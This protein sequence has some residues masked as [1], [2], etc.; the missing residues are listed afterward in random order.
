MKGALSWQPQ[1][2]HLFVAFNTHLL[3]G[4]PLS[5]PGK[6]INDT[7]VATLMHQRAVAGYQMNCKDNTKIV[8]KDT[9]LLSLWT[10]LERIHDSPLKD[11]YFRGV[12]N[13]WTGTDKGRRASPGS[14]PRMADNKADQ[15]YINTNTKNIDQRRSALSACGF[16][17]TI[18]GLD[19]VLLDLQEQEE[20]DKA[21]AWA[22]FNGLPDRA[23]DILSDAKDP[24]QGFQRKLISMVLEGCR[25]NSTRNPTWQHLCDLLIK[26][27]DA[28]PYL[29][30]IFKYIASNDWTDVLDDPLIPLQERLVIALRF[31]E[32]NQLSGW[33]ARVL[34]T[35]TS[36]GDVQGL[37]VTGLYTHG[38]NLL[39]NY[40]D[41]TGDVQSAAFI[42][43]FVMPR[44]IQDARCEE[45]VECYRTLLDRWQLWRQRAKFDIERGKLMH[46]TED[47]AP[48][49][50]YV[51][52]SYCAQTL[53][54]RIVAPNVKSRDG[55]RVNVQASVSPS[56][57]NRMAGKQKINICSSC[58]KALPRCA[59]CL[60]NLGTPNDAMRQA[61][62]TN[63]A[64][65]EDPS[66]LNMWF[67][68]CQTCR[69]GGHAIHMSEWFKKHS[70]CPVSN[71]ACQCQP[72]S[73]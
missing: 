45:W 54:H 13:I 57:N 24:S 4:D 43:S 72:F 39:E 40:V 15:L 36:E 28:Q 12:Y 16:D 67:T 58:R 68:W 70:S 63:N 60:L 18:S 21:A 31:L 47:V 59:L 14:S 41:R 32:D 53:G 23:I 69:H 61:I 2:S 26:E 38:M 33:L 44:K 3:W 10:W 55:K 30:A 48:P 5:A 27:L 49:Q 52:C 46:A 62:V 66:G 37:M 22:M 6:T 29:R 1:G 9:R 17:M 42:A 11:V 34:D 25:G 71:C 35:V 56:T 65:S 7:D 73:E 64:I 19:Q 8:A 20:Y 51:R 50:V